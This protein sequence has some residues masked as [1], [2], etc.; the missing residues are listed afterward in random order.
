MLLSMLY[1]RLIT[2]RRTIYHLAWGFM[3]ILVTGVQSLGFGYSF[4][5][6]AS[7]IYTRQC[8]KPL[9]HNN[10][11]YMTEKLQF[12]VHTLFGHFFN[13]YL[14]G[15]DLV[16][17]Y[18]LYSTHVEH[19]GDTTILELACVSGVLFINYHNGRISWVACNVDD[20]VTIDH[21]MTFVVENMRIVNDGEFSQ[22]YTHDSGITFAFTRHVVAGQPIRTLACCGMD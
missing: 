22:T 13:D 20:L 21:L 7:C 5:F 17:R 6:R 18:S 16:R 9:A 2:I 4:S 3:F 11:S 8:W 15:R 12:P 19:N 1:T 10:F 14:L